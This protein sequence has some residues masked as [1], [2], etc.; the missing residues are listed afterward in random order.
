MLL[1]GNTKPRRGSAGQGPVPFH[2]EENVEASAGL[3]K[4]DG[5]GGD[6]TPPS[7]GWLK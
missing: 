6:G 7:A 4:D 1:D 3:S 5:A 2:Q